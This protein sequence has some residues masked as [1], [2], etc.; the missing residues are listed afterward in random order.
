M[1]KNN[2]AGFATSSL[3]V[4]NLNRVLRSIA[5]PPTKL[6]IPRANRVKI[7]SC[8]QDIEF[9]LQEDQIQFLTTVN[10]KV[11]VRR[12]IKSLVPEN[13]KEEE[14]VIRY[15]DLVKA[16][17]K[18]I[19]KE[20]TQEAK[21]KRSR[22]RKKARSSPPEAEQGDA[23]TA[24]R[25]RKCKSAA[26]DPPEPSNKVARAPV[27]ASVVQ[28]CGVLIAEDEIVSEPWRAQVD[29]LILG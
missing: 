25:S 11:K 10:N 4:F 28:I 16:R 20:S 27:S 7:E 29:R 18:Y 2:K 13:A 15:K 19:E 24:R 1:L 3:S 8:W 5:T 21:G 17:A 23:D 22:G 14:K 9:I 6:A 26:Q 12:S